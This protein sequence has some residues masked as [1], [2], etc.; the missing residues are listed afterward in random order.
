FGCLPRS[1]ILTIG[2]YQTG[3][4]TP[5]HI[6]A[7]MYTPILYAL[8]Y[9]ERRPTPA[10]RLDLSRVGQLTFYET[11]TDK[12]PC[13]RLAREALEHGGGGPLV[14]SGGDARAGAG[15]HALRGGRTVGAR[16][17][18]AELECDRQGGRG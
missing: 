4:D 1:I 16:L 9:P 5:P 3:S 10:A 6:I 14:G 18:Q 12:Y 13:L 17:A 15:D 7:D 8:T 11:D 2:Y